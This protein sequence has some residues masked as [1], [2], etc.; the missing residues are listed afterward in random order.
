MRT[1]RIDLLPLPNCHGK[2]PMVYNGKAIGTSNLPIYAAARWLLDNGAAFPDDIV[3][4]YRGETLCMSGNAGE[5]AKWT[6]EE[7]THGN[8]SLVLRHWKAFETLGE[9]SLAAKT[10]ESVSV[11]LP[12]WEGGS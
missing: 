10:A 6:V 11:A 3:E 7:T 1:R 2:T 4:T 8:P 9:S 5:L 12:A